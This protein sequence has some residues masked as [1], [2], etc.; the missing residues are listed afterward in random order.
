M[1]FERDSWQEIISTLRKNRLRSLLTA[2]GV[3][4]GIFMLIVMLGSGNGLKNG[5][6][7]RFE[8]A[9]TNSV[10]IWTNPTTKPYKG[11]PRGRAFYFDDG[12]VKALRDN[13]SEIKYLA[14]RC[15]I[16]ASSEGANNVTRRLMSGAFTIYGDSP[17]ILSIYSIKMDSGRFINNLDMLNK[18]K[19]AVLGTRVKEVLF[20][21]D[22]DPIGKYI[23]INGTYFQV[24][25]TFVIE[26]LNENDEDRETIFIPLTT[27]QQVYNWGNLVAW[28]SITSIDGIPASNVEK[29]AISLLARR[30]DVAPDDIHAFGHFNVEKE[31]KK[32]KGLFNGINGLIWFVGIFSLIAGVIG[33]SNIMLIIVKERTREI[34]IRRA[35]GATPWAIIKQ[36]I[37]ETILLTSFA[38]YAGLV[39]GVAAIELSAKLLKGMEGKMEMFKN[40]G[41]DFNVGI[42][43]L[44]ILI[45]SGALAGLIPA[46]RAITIKPVDAIRNE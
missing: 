34:G 40:P 19:V 14:P 12:D 10:F 18:R 11:F 44:F 31:F 8:K 9:A 43:A 24:V 28:L 2:F 15:R 32:V 22:E 23:E 37:L 20:E 42:M 26:G 45:I 7:Q 41:V 25:G 29:K 21:A 6:F 16:R 27:F 5:V 4:W 17:E 30:H 38:G 33:V 36:I 3:F 1:I 39:V 13:I 46:K 35:I